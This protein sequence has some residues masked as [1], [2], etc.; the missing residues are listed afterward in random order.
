VQTFMSRTG[1]G[2][3]QGEGKLAHPDQA[4]ASA[5]KSRAA[6]ETKVNYGRATAMER[7]AEAQRAYQR[8]TL[9]A[10]GELGETATA[11]E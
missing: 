2:D 6:A 9:T 10:A 8:A 11:E 1:A 7:A 4:M 5:D 3:D